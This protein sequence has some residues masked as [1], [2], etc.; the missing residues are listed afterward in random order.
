MAISNP[1]EL[2]SLHSPP[3]SFALEADDKQHQFSKKRN[4]RI[5]HYQEAMAEHKKISSIHEIMNSEATERESQSPMLAHLPTPQSASTQRNALP[6]IDTAL[7]T[8]RGH[9]RTMSE[10]LSSHYRSTSESTGQPA[11]PSF[12]EVRTQREAPITRY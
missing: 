3:S 4:L 6:A 10:T 9:Q 5:P 1:M 8:L 12:S 7:E 11:L 2:L